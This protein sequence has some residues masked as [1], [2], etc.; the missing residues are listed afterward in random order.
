MN[1]EFTYFVNKDLKKDVGDIHQDTVKAFWSDGKWAM[2]ELLTYL[3]SVTGPAKVYL[4]TFSISEASIRAFNTGIE[5][6]MI[7]ELHCLFD[8]TIKKNK[9]QLLYFANNIANNIKLAPN[10]SKVILIENDN[11]KLAVVGSANMTPNPRKEAGVIITV[12]SLY[13][14][15]F[16]HLTNAIADGIDFTFDIQP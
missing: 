15:Y 11:W 7:T 9:V 4:S 8:Y 10:H 12:H 1:T 3:L 6:K 14:E 13:D 16:T 2:Y 5:A